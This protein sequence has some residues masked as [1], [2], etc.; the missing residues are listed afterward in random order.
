MLPP[1]IVNRF[2]A[3]I[4]KLVTVY[5]DD[6]PWQNE[7]L[8]LIPDFVARAQ[9]IFGP[10]LPHVNF[11]LF[12]TYRNLVRHYRELT[13]CA[14]PRGQDGTGGLRSDGHAFILI[15]EVRRNGRVTDIGNVIHEYGHALCNTIYGGMYLYH[16]PPW[17][18]EGVADY[19]GLPWYADLYRSAPELIREEARADRVPTYDVLISDFYEY[20]NAAYAIARLMVYALLRNLETIDA[21]WQ[22]LQ[23]AG[24]ANGAF[25]EV[26]EKIGGYR[27]EDLYERVLSECLAGTRS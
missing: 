6:T 16:V 5:A 11:Y 1:K 2:D 4:E 3:S 8:R 23:E 24:K 25:P 14:H 22:I 27:T 17:F 13:G 12:K 21:I 9:D 15:S 10:D 26:I 18:N 7:V 20:D 19:I